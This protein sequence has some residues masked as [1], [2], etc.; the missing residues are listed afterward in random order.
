MGCR[1]QG[2]NHVDHVSLQILV[3][4]S[5]QIISFFRAHDWKVEWATETLAAKEKSKNNLNNKVKSP[6]KTEKTYIN[7]KWVSNRVLT[8]YNFLS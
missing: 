7:N 3:S 6:P 4:V 2:P 5:Q 1:L 8:E